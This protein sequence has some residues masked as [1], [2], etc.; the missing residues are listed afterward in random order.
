MENHNVILKVNKLVSS[1]ANQAGILID[2][3]LVDNHSVPK[4]EVARMLSEL[5]DCSLT[6]SGA[7]VDTYLASR[8]DLQSNRGPGGGISRKDHLKPQF[9]TV[10]SQKIIE[11]VAE[12]LS[13]M[14]PSE[15]TETRT[16]T[17]QVAQQS[18]LPAR[19][20]K[21]YIIKYLRTRDDV[22]LNRGRKGGIVKIS[23]AA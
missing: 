14:K 22:Q 4:K 8:D 3:S 23:K 21:N 19:E 10:N 20:C 12:N 16:L 17:L 7:I 1:L 11:L 18:S 2:S 13:K 6:L 9:A 5:N 15:K